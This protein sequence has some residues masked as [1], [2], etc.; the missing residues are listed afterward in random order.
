MD[1]KTLLLVTA[2]A[3]GGLYFLGLT[4]MSSAQIELRSV[5]SVS[6]DA[7]IYTLMLTLPMFA[8]LFLIERIGWEPIVEL[9]NEIDEKVRPIFSKC[10]LVDLGLIAFFAG[11][12]EEIFFRGWMQAVLVERSGGLIGILI[13]SFIFGLLH[14]LSTAYAI[15]AFVTGIYLGIIYFATGNLFIVMAIHAIYDFVALVYLVVKGDK[16]TGDNSS[17]KDKISGES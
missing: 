4:L 13:T 2:F 12:G 17:D 5:F 1:R 15:Y 6:W 16:E 9:R 3:E 14:Y 11:V 7:A 10:N 8:T